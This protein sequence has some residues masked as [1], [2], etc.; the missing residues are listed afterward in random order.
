MA[1]LGDNPIPGTTGYAEVIE[2]FA[3]ASQA[4]DFAVV[5]CAFVP[6][7]P[8]SGASVL[9]V[10]AGIGQNAAAL[11]RRGFRVTAVEPL[12]V[13]RERGQRLFKDLTIKWCADALPDMTSF[14]ARG[15]SFAFIL[16]EGVWHHLDE[17]ERRAA[18][19]RLHGLLS[20]GG[21]LALSLRSGPPGA[22]TWVFPTD[23]GTTR[24]E[25]EALGF[26]C[27]WASENEPSVYPHRPQVRWARLV[28]AKRG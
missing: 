3:S 19:S 22:G 24:R 23:P 13:F 2:R 28:L 27:R 6:F 15:T 1:R 5:C 10:G 4:L 16:V 20:L 21:C 9:D 7:L 25:A 12:A 26:H 18:L 14:A 8:A 11:A 17:P